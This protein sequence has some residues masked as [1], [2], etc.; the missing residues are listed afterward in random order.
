[1]RGGHLSTSKAVKKF[2]SPSNETHP[3]LELNQGGRGASSIVQM[4]VVCT[5]VRGT[6]ASGEIMAL[7]SGSP[8]YET[9][10]L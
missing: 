3:A 1:M 6:M 8:R 9:Q 4:S 5:K 7:E 10:F 2:M